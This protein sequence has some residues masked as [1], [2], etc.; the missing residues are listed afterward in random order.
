MSSPWPIFYLSPL[1]LLLSQA[2]CAP[3]SLAS[4]Q[5]QVHTHLRVF[6]LNCS[7]THL[8]QAVIVRVIISLP[9][10][11]LHENIT[12]LM[13]FCLFCSLKY[14]NQLEQC[15]QEVCLR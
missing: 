6:A 2:H 12:S 1:P 4:P 9:V 7:S 5:A 14:L 8:L 3:A 10:S 15:T 13:E 11:C